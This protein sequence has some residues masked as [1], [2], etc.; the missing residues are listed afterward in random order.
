M[1]YSDDERSTSD[2]EPLELFEFIGP[3]VTYRYATGDQPFTLN[4]NLFTPTQAS[5]SAVGAAGVSDAPSLTVRVPVSS[6]VAID[7]SFATQPRSLRLRVYR[8]QVSSADYRLVWDGRVTGITPEGRWATARSESNFGSA[9]D[10]NVPAIS[11]QRHCNHF[12]YSVTCK[13][14]RLDFDLATQVTNVNGAI[15]TVA[16]IGGQAD[17]WFRAGE[18]VRDVDGERRTIVDQTGAVLTLASAF[19]TLAN[20]NSVTLYAGCDHLIATC[21]AKFNNRENFGGHP[22]VPS[23]NPF[24]VPINLTRGT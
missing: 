5:A 20:G 10:A 11:F 15:V 24:L 9:L 13:V 2:G 12:L 1:A 17:Q 6:Q 8:W 21:H 3:Q 4:G 19:R 23:S 16:S 18:I 7:Y 14:N 22:G